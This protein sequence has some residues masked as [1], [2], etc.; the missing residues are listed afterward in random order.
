MY[1]LIEEHVLK[2]IVTYDDLSFHFFL[3][4]ILMIIKTKNIFEKNVITIIDKNEG[5][6]RLYKR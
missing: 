4:K 5:K 1:P 2:F 3:K 6:K